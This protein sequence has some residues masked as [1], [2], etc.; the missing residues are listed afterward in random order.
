M[1]VPKHFKSFELFPPDILAQNAYMGDKI[2]W[3]IDDRVLWT[4]DQLRERY[5]KVYMNTWYWGGN[6][7][8]R[9]YRSFDCQVGAKWSQ[10]KF[11]RAS[12]LDFAEVEAEEVRQDI[13]KNPFDP[14]F[15]HITAI[16]MDISWFHYD[17]RNWDK[18]K[19]DI[20]QIK[21]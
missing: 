1:Y 10:H 4:N 2:F 18:A 19:N 3:L 13:L 11:G 21:P 17:V 16:E 12:D 8:Y 15:E 20:L 5:G 7:Q 14:I 6:H 9:G